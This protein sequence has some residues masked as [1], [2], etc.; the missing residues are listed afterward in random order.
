MLRKVVSTL[1]SKYLGRYVEGLEDKKLGVS[2]SN[3]DLELSELR[4]RDDSLDDLELPVM[5]QAGLLS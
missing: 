2:V 5:L 1:L 3:G 4:L